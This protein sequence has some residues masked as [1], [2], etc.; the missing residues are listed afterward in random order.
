MFSIISEEFVAVECERDEGIVEYFWSIFGIRSDKFGFEYH[1]PT[2]G[3][4]SIN[5]YNCK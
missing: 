4:M 5:N 1:T 3:L 2:S